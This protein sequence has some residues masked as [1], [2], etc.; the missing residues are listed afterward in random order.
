[1]GKNPLVNV[2]VGR[3]QIAHVVYMKIHPF[4]SEE[5]KEVNGLEI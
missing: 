2:F 4:L 5:P 3:R 1:M